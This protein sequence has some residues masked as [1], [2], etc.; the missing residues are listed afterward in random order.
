MPKVTVTTRTGNENK[1]DVQAVQSLMEGLRAANVGDIQATCGGCGA[2]CTCQVYVD[3]AQLHMLPPLSEDEDA[4]L[5]GSDVR[6]PNS[7]LSCQIQMTEELDGL[8]VTVAP[9]T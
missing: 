7:R 8:R 3:P 5:D 1:V 6:R 4:L 2:C 9:D